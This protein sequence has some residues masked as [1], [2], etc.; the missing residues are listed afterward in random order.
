MVICSLANPTAG[1]CVPWLCNLLSVNNQHK[2]ET[3]PAMVGVY[4]PVIKA[5]G[6]LPYQGHTNIHKEDLQGGKGRVGGGGGGG[7]GWGVQALGSILN[8]SFKK[9]HHYT[10]MLLIFPIPH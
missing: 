3:L 10:F 9:S 2:R 7:R 5:K 1:T 6:G 8:V 4:G